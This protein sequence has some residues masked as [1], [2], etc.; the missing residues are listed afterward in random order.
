MFLDTDQNP[1]TGCARGTFGA[2]YALVAYSLGSGERFLLGRCA[3]GRWRF[4]RARALAGSFAAAALTFTLRRGVLPARSG[5]SFRIGSSGAGAA[6]PAYDFAPDAG[7]ASW[8]Y[9]LAAPAS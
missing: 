6:R 8:R 2:E 4:G 7:E 9:A 1:R 5:F 3:R